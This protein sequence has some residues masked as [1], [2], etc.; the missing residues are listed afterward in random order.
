M[1]NYFRPARWDYL[2][3]LV[4][5]SICVLFGAFIFSNPNVYTILIMGG[6]LAGS[7]LFMT[8]GYSLSGKQLIIHRPLMNKSFDLEGLQKIHAD[9]NAMKRS[10]RLMGNGGL[11][12]WTG[13]F[14]N[15]HL[16]TYKA[17]VTNRYRCV[18]L[19]L[20]TTTIVLSPKNPER[21]MHRLREHLGRE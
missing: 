15:R 6:I 5:A 3:S 18:V 21:F 10:W 9:P 19:Q 14:R 11:F 1:Q 12:G 20:E 16:G 2:L 13:T 7:L 8:R 17:Y 4:T